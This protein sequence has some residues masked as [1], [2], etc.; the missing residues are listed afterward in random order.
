MRLW[1]LLALHA[2]TPKDDTATEK[3][4]DSGDSARLACEP[5]DVDPEPTWEGHPSDGWRWAKH[6]ALFEDGE[7]VG[8]ADGDLA[9]TLVEGAHGLHLVFTRQRGLDQDL[10]VSTSSDGEIW[11][12]PVAATGLESGSAGYAGLLYDQGS[13]RLWYGSGNIVY[14]ISA[15]GYAFEALGATLTT[16]ESGAFDSV[17]VLYPSP[18]ASDGW[19]GLAYTGFDGQTYAMGV[20]ES[21]DDGQTWE[22]GQYIVERVPDGWDNAAVA[23]PM[24]VERAGTTHVWYGGYDTSVTDPGPWRVG[25]S[26]VLN[27]DRRVSLPLSETGPDAW[28]TRDPAV[29]PWGDGWLMVYAGMG[30]DGVYRLMRATSDVCN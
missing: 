19:L 7:M 9:P 27:S 14:A 30:D 28:S 2:C 16:G 15:D 20:V 18:I 23:Q 1:V 6:G 4:F 13:Y 10:W 24:V 12:P 3:P 11:G 21:A 8:Y 25:Y 26:P 22:R 5:V 17:S 29:V